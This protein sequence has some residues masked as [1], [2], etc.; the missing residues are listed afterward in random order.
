MIGTVH[1]LTIAI[2]AITLAARRGIDRNAGVGAAL[3][4][5]AGS[6]VWRWRIVP[7]VCG[8]AFFGF[9]VWLAA[10]G[11]IGLRTWAW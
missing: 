2:C 11:L 4:D 7:T 10:N 9:T 5:P 6:R 8:F 3:V 1:P